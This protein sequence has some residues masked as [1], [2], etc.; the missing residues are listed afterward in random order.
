[1]Q[2]YKTQRTI[3]FWL[4][5]I[6]DIIVTFLLSSILIFAV[7]QIILRNFFESGIIWAD[8]LLRILVLWLALAGAI[9]ASRQ[10][11]QINID[12]FSQF[13]PDAYKHYIEKLN[14]LFASAIC[15]LISYY[16]FQFVSLEYETGGYA[17]AEVPAWIA[18]AV[19]PLGF[20]I[21]GVRYLAQTLMH[22]KKSSTP[23]S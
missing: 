23:E 18:E 12:I 8:S 3:I 4:H 14:F 7:T 20:A 11:K 19:I 17:F 13:I 16:S 1:M 22:N 21:M 9:L 2:K 15:L 5:R 10:G 6:E